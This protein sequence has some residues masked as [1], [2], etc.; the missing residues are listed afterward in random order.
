M[1]MKFP[2]YLLIFIFCV[3]IVF[4]ILG[5]GMN[6]VSTSMSNSI[7][8]T[9]INQHTAQIPI[10]LEIFNPKN[11]PIPVQYIEYDVYLNNDIIASAKRTSL[12]VSDSQYEISQSHNAVFSD[13]VTQIFPVI[14]TVIG[15][16]YAVGFVHEFRY[17]VKISI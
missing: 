12:L 14:V 15:T 5:F 1:S 17:D 11:I 4:A 10:E 13:N 7:D 8:A 16:I 2:I 3:S 6:S 9:I